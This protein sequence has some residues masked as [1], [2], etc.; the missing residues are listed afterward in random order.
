ME[1]KA[2]VNRRVTWVQLIIS[3][4]L[5]TITLICSLRSFQEES[6]KEMMEVFFQRVEEDETKQ[7]ICIKKEQMSITFF[8]RLM[9]WINTKIFICILTI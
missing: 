3:F 1:R 5:T 4:T 6:Y 9:C 2:R 7:C 8:E